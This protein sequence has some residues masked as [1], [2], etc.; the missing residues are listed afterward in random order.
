MRVVWRQ[1]RCDALLAIYSHTPTDSSCGCHHPYS[2]AAHS[3]FYPTLPLVE[4]AWS[5]RLLLEARVLSP[6]AELNLEPLLI[7]FSGIAAPH[8][9]RPTC[10]G[11]E[12]RVAW[13]CRDVLQCYRAPCAIACDKLRIV[14]YLQGDRSSVQGVLTIIKVILL[15]VLLSVGHITV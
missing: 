9:R 3:R 6:R 5:T 15:R 12:H 14:P 7:T 8:G 10:G 11:P 2:K 13:R 4:G 1:I